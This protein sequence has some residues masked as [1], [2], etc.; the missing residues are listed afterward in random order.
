VATSAEYRRRSR[1]W[2]G[3]DILIGSTARGGAA[4]TARAFD[5]EIVDYH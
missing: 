2:S 3:P 5:V 4:E 1:V